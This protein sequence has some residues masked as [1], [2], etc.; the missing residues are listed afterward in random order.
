MKATD[1]KYSETLLASV[2]GPCTSTTA[3]LVDSIDQDIDIDRL[4]CIRRTHQ[5]CKGDI[6]NNV[7]FAFPDHLLY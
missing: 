3:F 7:G 1:T 4:I 2:R 5:L 6:H